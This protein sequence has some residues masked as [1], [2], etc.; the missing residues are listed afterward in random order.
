MFVYYASWIVL[1]YWF[2]FSGMVQLLL[3][4]V[5]LVPKK[6]VIVF[7]I[8]W[9]PLVLYE[10]YCELETSTFVLDDVS[11]FLLAVYRPPHTSVD[12]IDIF[13][14]SLEKCLESFS[15]LNQWIIV[16]VI[17]CRLVSVFIVHCCIVHWKIIK[18][19]VVI[20]PTWHS[21]FVY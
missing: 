19:Y 8:I 21:V 10:G 4:F 12:S 9:C 1:N 18:T 14:D 15:K 5:V 11:C 2:L 6:V 3:V 20:R 13:I 16:P 17:S 7:L